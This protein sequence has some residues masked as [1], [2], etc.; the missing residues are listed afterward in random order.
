MAGLTTST[1]PGEPA[2]E[3]GPDSDFQA[4]ADPNGPA[5]ADPVVAEPATEQAT[6]SEE[7]PSDD[8]EAEEAGSDVTPPANPGAAT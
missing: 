2:G 5:E 8:V 4:G 7:T 6:P 3:Q 1:P